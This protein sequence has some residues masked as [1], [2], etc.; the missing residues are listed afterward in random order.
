M[1][2]P[3]HVPDTL[4]PGGLEQIVREIAG[5]RDT[6]GA[7]TIAVGSIADRVLAG[8]TFSSPAEQAQARLRIEHEV[9]R[10]ASQVKG[11]RYLENE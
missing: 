6:F 4:T 10:L 3:Y 1:P 5:E 7:S 2:C 8:C 11:L 9:A